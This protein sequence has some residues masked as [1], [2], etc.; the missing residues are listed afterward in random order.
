MERQLSGDTNMA[1]MSSMLSENDGPPLLGDPGSLPP[2][3]NITSILS[4]NLNND[5]L[6]LKDSV[7]L[8]T[9]EL[10]KVVVARRGLNRG[11][12]Q[13]RTN[14]MSY[15]EKLEELQWEINN[16]RTILS[17]LENIST[18]GKTTSFVSDLAVQKDAVGD[19]I[20]ALIGQ[21]RNNHV[22]ELEQTR[23]DHMLQV[24]TQKDDE[25][26]HLKQQLLIA[27]N[28]STD[29]EMAQ[30]E[31]KLSELDDVTYECDTL[32][33]TIITL[34]VQIALLK[35]EIISMQ[36]ASQSTYDEIDDFSTFSK[37]NSKSK[38]VLKFVPEPIPKPAEI[39]PPLPPPRH[40]ATPQRPVPPIPE[41]LGAK[42]IEDLEAV[43]NKLTAARMSL[44]VERDGLQKAVSIARQEKNEL[45][46]KFN[47]KLAD[48]GKLETELRAG[49]R[50]KESILQE[51]DILNRA[52]SLVTNELNSLK[53]S[54][55]ASQVEISNLK[56]KCE[57]A[58]NKYQEHQ[59]SSDSSDLEHAVQQP[60]PIE[61]KIDPI[62]L[63]ANEDMQQ[64][65]NS[66]DVE[67]TENPTATTT[68][69]W[70]DVSVSEE[71]SNELLDII[72]IETLDSCVKE[73]D[74]VRDEQAR[75]AESSD[76]EPVDLEGSG[77]LSVNKMGREKEREREDSGVM[78]DDIEIEKM[79]ELLKVQD[80]EIER[81]GEKLKEKEENIVEQ[82]M[83]MRQQRANMNK[84][85]E[86]TELLYN[87][88]IEELKRQ[89]VQGL[90]T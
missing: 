8:D 67:K 30:M 27:N 90:A 16:E 59:K 31:S 63:Q 57:E 65:T 47:V 83:K 4:E 69:F 77:L 46:L 18:E 13:Q 41:I 43:V 14:V 10:P 85:L 36:Y 76:W 81:L 26:N 38:P 25:I 61:Y 19:R 24:I 66:E 23:I 80:K 48:I 49:R 87:N 5:S 51:R 3:S 71:S 73:E 70:D 58:E 32:R 21:I 33:K 88:T 28:N 56:M 42:R 39:E 68:T 86:Q 55:E 9:P 40:W 53:E 2:D 1:S 72:K 52:L 82:G 20:Q 62:V 44:L 17:K 60:V 78:E 75:A 54:Y 84:E 12:Q 6:K 45:K 15:K 89:Q 35:A 22:E 37:R 64:E 34:N 29:R 11:R 74:N 79:L 7:N 50:E